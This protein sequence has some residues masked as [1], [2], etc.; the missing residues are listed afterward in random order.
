MTFAFLG[1]VIIVFF[2]WL[3]PQ[4]ALKVKRYD[5]LTQKGER[6]LIIS[7]MHNNGLLPF[8]LFE[9]VLKKERLTG[10]FLL[11]DLIDRKKGYKNTSL[12]LDIIGKENVPIYYVRGNHE[13]NSLEKDQ[14]FADL[15][16]LGAICLEE[17]QYQHGDFVLS[18]MAFEKPPKYKADIYLC[19]NPMDA[20]KG[21]FS[22]LY[23]AGH[24]HGG[25]VRFPFIGAIYVPGQKIFPKYQKGLY[26]L[27]HKQLLITSGIGNT[28]LP[29]RF[30]NPIEII[31][32]S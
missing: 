10:I 16:K 9:K 24:T 19:H 7:D 29:I 8:D 15:N 21:S 18:G 13:S 4:K 28:F 20:L 30:L 17:K 1:C 31:I 25:M 32:L 11:G 6:F 5:L 12:L 2:I 14:L 22:G 26:K 27:D 3:Y 23:L